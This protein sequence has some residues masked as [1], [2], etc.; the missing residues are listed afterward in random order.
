MAPWIGWHASNVLTAPGERCASPY[1]DLILSPSKDEV[2]ASRP[3][4]WF[5][6]LTMR[7]PG[8]WFPIAPPE[9]LILSPSKDEV[10]V[11]LRL[12]FSREN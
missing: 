11:H 10:R 12:D 5:D 3:V 6:K 1:E 2:R 9:D 7:P 8:S 4:S